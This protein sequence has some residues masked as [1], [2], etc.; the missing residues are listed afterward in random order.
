MARAGGPRRIGS[1]RS[2]VNLNGTV[3]QRMTPWA[4]RWRRQAI[5]WA[6]NG[7]DLLFPPRCRWCRGEGEPA[8]RG[9]CDACVREFADARERCLRCGASGQGGSGA[10]CTACRRGQPAW[11]GIVV[12]GGYAD[13][14]RDAVL[15][16]KRPGAEDVAQALAS[17]LVDRHRAVLERAR[18]DA[19]V[20]VPM[21]WWRRAGRGT[22]AAAEI[23]RAVARELDVD[24]VSALVRSRPT[25]MQNELPAEDRGANVAGAFRTRTTVAGRR[26]L[27]VD[28]V[29]TT[30]STLAACCHALQA[31]GAAGVHVAALAKADRWGE[32]S[33][34][35][36]SS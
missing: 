20:P 1:A 25:R 22:S 33:E 7:V 28:D 13:A 36:A 18:V 26:I 6:G 19:V 15:R 9:L 32:E 30:G 2:L 8:P 31:S 12:L 4:H 21:H 17:L 16:V 10:G 14:L 23:A 24:V 35:G 34:R 3:G 5:R 11:E 27:V 29:V